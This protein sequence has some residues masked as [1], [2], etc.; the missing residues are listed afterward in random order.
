[1]REGD[2]RSGGGA[3]VIE[4]QNVGSD[5][6]QREAPDGPSL[7][8][9][10]GTRG[11][12]PF[13]VW[14]A[15]L[16][17]ASWA[18]L[19]ILESQLTFF[20]DEWKF[21]LD[22]RGWAVGDFLDP[23]NDHIA[24]APVAIYKLLLSIF[25][26]ESAFPFQV[27]STLVFLLSAVVL[28][29]YLRRRV[30][31]WPALLGSALI[32]FLG[33]AY[34]DLLW[35][36]Q[37][38][39]TGSVAA[40]L[41]AL[42]ALD[43][44]DRTGDRMACA[45]LTVSTSFSE[46]GVPFVAGALVNVLVGERPRIRRLYVAF[47]PLALYA[48]W[49]LGWGHEATGTFSVDNVL[50]SPKFVFDAASQAAASLLGLGT[51]L[52]A[53]E[54]DPPASWRDPV[55]LNWGRILL[56]AGLAL[57]IWRFR[58][59]GRVPRPFWVALAV[60]A[61]FWFLTAFN[62]L[63]PFRTPTTIRYQYPGAVFLLL[64]AAE[65]LREVR[66]NR[67][68][69]ALG[70]AVT[71]L[72]VLSGLWFIH[73]GYSKRQKP[74]SD[75]LRGSLTAIEIARDQVPPEFGIFSGGRSPIIA[76]SYFSAADAYG[77]PAYSEPEL[78]S[79]PA[80]AR[81]AADHTLVGA[82]GIE[83]ASKQGSPS[84][85]QEGGASSCRTVTATPAG[86]TGLAFSSGEI[87]LRPRRGTSAD[88]L[89][90]RFADGFPVSLGRLRVG[91]ASSVML[92]V[93]RSPR[94]WRLGLRGEGRVTV[95]GRPTSPAPGGGTPTPPATTTGGGPQPV[96]AGVF[97]GEIEGTDA[98]IALVTNG[99]RLSG[100]YLCSPNG[101]VWFRPATFADGTADLVT[102]SGDNLG[103]ASFAGESASGNVDIG[104]DSHSFSAEPA[105]GRAGLYRTASGKPESEGGVS[106][107]GW[108][109]LPD[110]SKCGRTNSITPGGDFKTEP[111]TSR[112]KGHVTEFTNPFAF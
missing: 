29:L 16:T 11:W 13:I 37:M 59:L 111:A 48:I 78:G 19:L 109:V 35:P 60:G 12:N 53:S 34:I 30:G 18:L 93:D 15:V 7:E 14:L 73:L 31:D 75:R 10:D 22:R 63:P 95:C 84:R 87:T 81:F 36:F 1:V 56:V 92:P 71:A 110:G 102:R 70:T 107:T 79:S 58:R 89:L 62:A 65:V 9:A 43:R 24:L 68:A 52:H 88:V 104:G 28:F 103:E 38:G 27:V 98:E 106:E 86:Q 39:F 85:A 112:P 26:M 96:S 41:G 21:I 40:G 20:A 44:D 69:L 5:G 94:P 8:R 64:I 2:R 61:S 91:R 105:T 90:G 54:H 100:A 55:G 45:L 46:V 83:L 32:L 72:A 3:A 47:I 80:T 77:S 33:A 101:A 25:G 49:W 51:P 6:P 4:P 23:H 42:L 17:A 97:V 67:R 99:E 66:M 50:E 57:T 82:L 108:I 76:R 74:L